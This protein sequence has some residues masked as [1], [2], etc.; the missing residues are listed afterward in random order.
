MTKSEQILNTNTIEI[1]NYTGRIYSADSLHS[2]KS[3]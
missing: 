2:S 3:V 1:L